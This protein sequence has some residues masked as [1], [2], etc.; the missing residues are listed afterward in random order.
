MRVLFSS[1]T[2]YGHVFPMVPLAQ[3]LAAAGHEVL[4]AGTAEVGQ[5]VA[6]A[7]IASAPAG[8]DGQVLCD[9]MA[10]LKRRAGQHAPADRAAFMF[11][12]MFG[13]TLTPPMAAD[14]LPLAR[15]WQPDLL[16]HEHGEL[17]SP[18]VGA[19]LGVPSVTHAFGGAV[20]PAFLAEAARRIEHLWSAEGLDIPPYAGCF[21]TLY[22]DI[23][24]PSVQAVPVDHIGTRQPLRPE[25][26]TGPPSGAAGWD[27]PLVYLTLGTVQNHQP[28]LSVAL[29]SLAELGLRVVVTVGHDGDPSALGEQPANV[30]VERFVPQAELLPQAAVVASHCGSG[31]FLGALAAGVPQLCLPQA[32]D[33]F[34]NA[35]AGA[36]AGA[37]LV[38]TPDEATG[39]AIGAAVRRLL[40]EPSF[41]VAAQGVA[42]EIAAMPGPADVVEVLTALL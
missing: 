23:C 40:D 37:A 34:R 13:E 31:T 38:L 41:R 14:L 9:V 6:D 3:G 15:D 22:L 33:Q 28:V 25:S 35:A 4:W 21:D 11:P 16:V 10:D 39:E 32:A 7:G 24:P 36:R 1:A 20:P 27:G 19:V 18:L 42:A 29:R 17:A 8:L 26:W 30:S 12:T 2:G 5:L